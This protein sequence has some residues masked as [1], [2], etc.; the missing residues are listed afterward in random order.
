MSYSPLNVIA[1]VNIFG[2][3]TSQLGLNDQ[4]PNQ[5]ENQRRAIIPKRSDSRNPR[6][7]FRNEVLKSIEGESRGGRN[8]LVKSSAAI[9]K[10]RFR[11]AGITEC[12]ESPVSM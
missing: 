4:P 11:V 9:Q 2:L 8:H 7:V 10:I 1:Y 3:D 5:P 12:D 6:K